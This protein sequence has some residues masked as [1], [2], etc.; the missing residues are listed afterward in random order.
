MA[1]IPGYDGRLDWGWGI[2]SDATFNI[3]GWTLNATADMHETTTFADDGEKT[4]IRGT[5]GWTASVEALVD[6]TNNVAA[7]M[8]G[9]DASLKLYVNSTYYYTGTGLL[10]NYSPAV[11]VDG[12]QTQTLEFQGTGSLSYTS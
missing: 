10:S 4:F 7:S 5:R 9:S 6:S 8:I 2:I 11:S 1:E 12:V 3:R